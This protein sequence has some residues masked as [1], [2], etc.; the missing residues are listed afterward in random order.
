MNIQTIILEN[1]TNK[2]LIDKMTDEQFEKMCSLLQTVFSVGQFEN[3]ELLFNDLSIND[4][5]P[6]Q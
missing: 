2:I 5:L 4:S 1:G 6:R 3:A